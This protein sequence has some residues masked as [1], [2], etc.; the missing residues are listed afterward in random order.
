M[1]DLESANAWEAH[2]T[3]FPST[4]P[5][6]LEH[7]P[8]YANYQVLADRSFGHALGPLVI[9]MATGFTAKSTEFQVIKT[10]FRHY[11]IARQLN[12]D[13]HDWQQDLSA[14]RI[15]SVAARLLDRWGQKEQVKEVDLGDSAV[16]TAMQTLFWEETVHETIKLVEEHLIAARTALN[17]CQAV[18]ILDMF[19]ELLRPLEL[20]VTKAR[21]ETKR[22]QEFLGAYSQG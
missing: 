14:G 6:N 5:L 9:L 18:E 15:N 21:Y 12:D 22:A 3:R 2:N 11:L 17:N 20:A 19:E 4:H 1:D 10:F 8:D 7:L 16:I 13:A